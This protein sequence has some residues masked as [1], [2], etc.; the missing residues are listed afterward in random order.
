MRARQV[1]RC[2]DRARFRRLREP[3]FVRGAWNA[4][5]LALLK[6]AR[7]FHNG[8]ANIEGVTNS[9]LSAGGRVSKTVRC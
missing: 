5:K 9:K 6:F 2:Y 7:E 4:F 1:S 3:L 8:A